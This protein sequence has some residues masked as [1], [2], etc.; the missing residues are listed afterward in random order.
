MFTVVVEA[1]DRYPLWYRFVAIV[2][3]IV[4]GH[5]ATFNLFSGLLLDHSEF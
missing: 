4:G 2:A 5:L 1:V 3:V